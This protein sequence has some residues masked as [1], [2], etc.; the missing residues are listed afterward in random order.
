MVP[1]ILVVI[2]ASEAKGN[3]RLKDLCQR[4]A[5][6]LGDPWKVEMLKNYVPLLLR[7]AVTIVEGALAAVEC[8]IVRAG[9]RDYQGG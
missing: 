3:E 6:S 2:R 9:R 7:P 5:M 4:C 1:C 8:E